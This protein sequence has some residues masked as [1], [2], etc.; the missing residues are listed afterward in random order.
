MKIQKVVCDKCKKEIHGLVYT[1]SVGYAEAQAI[2][3]CE[4]PKYLSYELCGDCLK[5]VIT[6][7]V[8]GSPYMC[9]PKYAS[10]DFSQ[11]YFV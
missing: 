10:Y 4:M 5:D 3:A 1:V 2:H 11:A 6:E 7:D 8:K 9:V